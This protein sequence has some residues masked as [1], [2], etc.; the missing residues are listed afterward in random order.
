M[1][2]DQTFITKLQKRN[3]YLFNNYIDLAGRL[4]SLDL[5][6]KDVL[7][8]IIYETIQD[9]KENKKDS[10]YDKDPEYISYIESELYQSASFFSKQKDI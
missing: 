5:I 3:I 8:K 6:T 2:Q 7:D 4:Y 10:I 1:I 9:F